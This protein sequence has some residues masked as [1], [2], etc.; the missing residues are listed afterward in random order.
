VRDAIEVGRLTLTRVAPRWVWFGHLAEDLPGGR[1]RSTRVRAHE[2]AGGGWSASVWV[3]V[4]GGGM[5]VN[6]A[7]V[8]GVGDSAELAIR[9]A[10]GPALTPRPL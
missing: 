1:S 4:F 8:K 3:D 5:S 9:G 10:L 6:S 2:L 7:E